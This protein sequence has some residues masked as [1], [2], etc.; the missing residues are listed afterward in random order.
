M[1]RNNT[2]HSFIFISVS[3]AQ[4]KTQQN[5]TQQRVF[6]AEC[7]LLHCYAECLNGE[8]H[9]AGCRYAESIYVGCRNAGFCYDNFIKLIFIMLK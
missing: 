9:H 4:S 6:S 8:C 3:G 1:H 7:F 2:D 5:S